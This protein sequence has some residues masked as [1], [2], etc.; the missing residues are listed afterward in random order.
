MAAAT[1]SVE[2]DQFCCPVCLEVLRDPV[3][4]PCGHSYC[5]QCIED[6]WN[7]P[8]QKGQYTCPQ[9]RQVFNPRPLLSRNTV[10]GEVVEK[11]QRSGAQAAAGAEEGRCSVCTGRRS[12]AVKSCL[13][14]SESYCSAHLRTHEE[15]FHAKAH[16]LI[17]A[18][19][20]LCPL[21]DKLLR[22]YCHSDQ[23]SVCSQCVR[24]K[25]RGHDTGSALDGRAAQQK[26]LQEASLKS[27]QRLKDA[28]KE[29]RYVIR[30]IKHS[31]EAAVEESERIFSRLIRSIEKQSSE[32]KE[33]IK[34][35]QRAAVSQA[36]EVL[37][38]VQR[39]LVELRRTEAELEKLSH[40]DDHVHFLQ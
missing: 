40:T 4:I 35:Q 8:K 13:V 29:L 2:Q 6:Y 11:F 1:I 36:E 20:H 16:K 19:E 18:S 21:H 22:L 12:R 15:R 34:V 33:V 5:L 9:C 26:K 27:A 31:T 14:C 37:E 28:E 25:H 17:P 10:L 38:K 39:E 23:Q 24:E 3:T 7:R 32:V 30:Y